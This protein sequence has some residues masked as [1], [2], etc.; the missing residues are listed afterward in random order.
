MVSFVCM[1]AGFCLS[2]GGCKTG[3]VKLK[4]LIVFS[5][6]QNYLSLSWTVRSTCLEW[7]ECVN[8]SLTLRYKLRNILSHLIRNLGPLISVLLLFSKKY[9]VDCTETTPC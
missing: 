3:I 9:F 7:G 8:F 6:L 5:L 2:F 1:H 4:Q